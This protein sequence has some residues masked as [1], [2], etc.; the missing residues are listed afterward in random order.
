MNIDRALHL[1]LYSSIY[2][3]TA[4]RFTEL[5]W[6]LSNASDGSCNSLYM[7]AR[8][9]FITKNLPKSHLSLRDHT[10]ETEIQTDGHSQKSGFT[11]ISELR[12]QGSAYYASLCF[13]K[14]YYYCKWLWT[15]L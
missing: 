7:S 14:V 4:K 12:A 6:Y 3:K 8:D 1:L 13:A 9:S 2:S 11:R 10:E 5:A 15:Q